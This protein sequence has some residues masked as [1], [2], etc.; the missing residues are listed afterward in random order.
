MFRRSL[1]TTQPTFTLTC[2]NTK[3][4]VKRTFVEIVARICF[5]LSMS[6]SVSNIHHSQWDVLNERGYIFGEYGTT[7]RTGNDFNIPNGL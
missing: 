7:R 3:N 6:P 1:W 4:N 2:K 5:E